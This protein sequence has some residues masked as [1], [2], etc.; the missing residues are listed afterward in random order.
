MRR[1]DNRSMQAGARLRGMGQ[2]GLGTLLLLALLP[3]IA[4]AD[5]SG[6]ATL[7]TEYVYRG[8]TLSHGNPALQLGLDVDGKSGL[9]AGA[10]ASTIDAPGRYE[11]RRTELDFYVGYHSKREGDLGFTATVL[12]Y[13]YPG[14]TG[15]DSYDY[16]EGIVSVSY[17]ERLFVEYAYTNDFYGFDVQARDLSVRF[18]Q[19]AR[20][21]WIISGGVGRND[22]SDIG[23]GR[24][25][26]WD[27]GASARF[28]WLTVDLRWFDNERPSGFFATQSAGSQL[29]ASLST[30]F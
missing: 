15:I 26:H 25:L 21:A 16:V 12:G 30:G 29:V 22:L 9:F 24:F 18:E 4:G 7:T 8:L 1:G 2:A 19:P 20:N 28:H 23:G 14:H 11:S 27:I 10:W 6:S 3:R 13:T 5:W 17:R